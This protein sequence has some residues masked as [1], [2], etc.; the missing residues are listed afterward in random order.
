MALRK[1]APGAAFLACGIAFLGVGAATHDNTFFAMGPAFI[2][3]GIAL[4]ARARRSS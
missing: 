3:I 2:A 1:R 4:L